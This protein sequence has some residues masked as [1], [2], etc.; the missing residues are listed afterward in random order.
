MTDRDIETL[1]CAMLSFVVV[2][3]DFIV[4]AVLMEDH[5]GESVWWT[6]LRFAG[7]IGFAVAIIR[8][9]WRGRVA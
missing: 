6:L 2:L 7:A 1:W 8:R 4:V 3:W 5:K 9:I